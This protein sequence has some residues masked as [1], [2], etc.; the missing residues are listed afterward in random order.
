MTRAYTTSWTDCSAMFASGLQT[1]LLQ[2]V[3]ALP[4]ATGTPGLNLDRLTQRDAETSHA[5][6]A[7]YSPIVVLPLV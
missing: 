6:K 5:G 7:R 3:Q 2:D 1:P 4:L